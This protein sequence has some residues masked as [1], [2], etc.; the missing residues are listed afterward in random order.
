MVKARISP[1]P[2]LSTRNLLEHRR[3]FSGVGRRLTFRRA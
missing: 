3:S 1:Q 2:L